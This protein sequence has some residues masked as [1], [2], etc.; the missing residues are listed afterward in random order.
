MRKHIWIGMMLAVLCLAG[1]SGETVE[2]EKPD[3]AVGVVLKSI[4]SP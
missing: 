4:N 2:Q 3:Y 1:C